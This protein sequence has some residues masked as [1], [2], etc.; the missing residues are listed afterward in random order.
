[1]LIFVFADIGIVLLLDATKVA[2]Y[3]FSMHGPMNGKLEGRHYPSM[4]TKINPCIVGKNYRLRG[5]IWQRQFVGRIL[6]LE[7]RIE[8]SFSSNLEMK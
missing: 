5:N 1:M 7:P 8:H 2:H 6:V 4:K 3:Y